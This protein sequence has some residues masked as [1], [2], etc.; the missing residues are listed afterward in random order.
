M[1]RGNIELPTN[2]NPRNLSGPATAYEAARLNHEPVITKLDQLITYINNIPQSMDIAEAR[3]SILAL[4]PSFF[5]RNPDMKNAIESANSVN[6]LKAL[7]SEGGIFAS[8]KQREEQDLREAERIYEQRLNEEVRRYEAEQVRLDQIVE[9]ALTILRNSGLD[10]L[11]QDT[12][13]FMLAQ[14]TGSIELD[15]GISFDK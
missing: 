12:L 13:D 1:S 15:I 4:A 14:L 9:Q 2:F 7:A 10:I 8:K 11:G 3:E 5:M 6:A